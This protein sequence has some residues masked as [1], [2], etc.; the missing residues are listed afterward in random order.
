MNLHPEPPL[1]EIFQVKTPENRQ[2][3]K[4]RP[5]LVHS[6]C[7]L[8]W[9]MSASHG[10]ASSNRER[11]KKAKLAS[12]SNRFF[13]LQENNPKSSKQ[14][15]N[16]SSISLINMNSRRLQHLKEEEEAVRESSVA[17]SNSSQSGNERKSRSSSIESIDTPS[18]KKKDW[19]VRS[20]LDHPK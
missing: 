1:P 6:G 7:N 2:S 14:L 10:L 18:K 8:H 17:A 9:S 19:R 20:T 4:V 3:S 11:P 12:K 16:C 13:H 5:H 15:L